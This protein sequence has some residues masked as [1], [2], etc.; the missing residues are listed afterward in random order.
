MN[1][2]HFLWDE[3]KNLTNIKKH[4]ISFKEEITVFFI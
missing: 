2:I 1:N 3:S 4:K